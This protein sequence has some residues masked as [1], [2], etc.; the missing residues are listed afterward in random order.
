MIITTFEWHYYLTIPL[1]NKFNSNTIVES[2]E[3]LNYFTGFTT[4]GVQTLHD[5]YFKK[6]GLK[7]IVRV[8]GYYSMNVYPLTVYNMPNLTYIG[9]DH[10][11]L[12]GT[13]NP[14]NNAYS[15]AFYLPKLEHIYSLRYYWYGRG[16]LRWMVIGTNNGGKVV[17]CG[18]N[19]Y[20]MYMR[21]GPV[22]IFVPD[23][24]VENYKNTEPWSS[25]ATIIHGISEFKTLVTDVTGEELPSEE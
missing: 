17:T 9:N 8:E 19:N 1:S 13:T 25:G 12:L 6:I 3:E 22:G 20:Y 2:F 15:I 4:S 24:L 14:M 16:E 18:Y 7:N 11:M 5:C 21:K 23:E 10:D